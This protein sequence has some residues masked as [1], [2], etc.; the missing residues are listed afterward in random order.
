MPERY[1]IKNCDIDSIKK[2]E[3]KINLYTK[4]EIYDNIS[5]ILRSKFCDKSFISSVFEIIPNNIIIYSS[6]IITVMNS[7]IGE[8]TNYKELCEYIIKKTYNRSSRQGKNLC[9]ILKVRQ[10]YKKNTLNKLHKIVDINYDYWKIS[11]RR[12]VI[13]YRKKIRSNK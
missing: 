4:S 5:I 11:K 8:V 2:W 10:N 3:K 9:Y 1:R 6:L 12:S 13:M 7:Y